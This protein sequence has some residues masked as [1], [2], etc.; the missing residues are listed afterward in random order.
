MDKATEQHSTPGVSAS[1]TYVPNYPSLRSLFRNHLQGEA[2]HSV[3]RELPRT[4]QRFDGV[5]LWHSACHLS[6][7]AISSCYN[8]LSCICL[9]TWSV[10]QSFLSPWFQGHGVSCGV[11]AEAFIAL[12]S[13]P[14]PAGTGRHSR[15]Q[16][17]GKPGDS[18]N[19]SMITSV[20]PNFMDPGGT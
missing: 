10:G 2:A 11:N 14:S 15:S 17:Q 5:V 12:N 9:L 16:H 4:G 7:S 8:T 18:L 20:R 13:Q 19:P 3:G 1:Q 6:V